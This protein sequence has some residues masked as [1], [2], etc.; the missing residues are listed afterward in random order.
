MVETLSNR[1]WVFLLRGFAA[2]L[3]GILAFVWPG[4]TLLSLTIL[5]GAYVFVDGILA[6]AAAFGGLAGSRWWAL[7]LEGIVCLI[8]AFF[9]WTEPLASTVALIYFVAAWA[10]VTG[11]I[12]IVAG[13]QLRD[14]I[15]NEWMYV[16]A[17]LASIVF[18]VL[19]VR[20]LGAGALAIAWLVGIY[21]IIFGVLQLALSY[22]L[23]RLHSVATTIHGT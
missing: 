11:I 3:F 9:V 16:L 4:I 22:R 15:S 1:W 14:H 20:N 23:N 7:L 10:I 8:V 17:G 5:F 6:L 19:V 21:A 13:I 18:G 12:E 2:L